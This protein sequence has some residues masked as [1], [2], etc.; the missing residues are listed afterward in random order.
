MD[1]NKIL[2]LIKSTKKLTVLFVED[3]DEVALNTLSI[4]KEFFGEI[5]YAKNGQEGV[6]KFNEETIDL[7]ISDINMP[8]LNGIEMLKEIKRLNSGVPALFMTAHN[9]LEY[10]QKAMD[11]NVK[12]YILKPMQLPKFIEI[13]EDIVAEIE[14]QNTTKSKIDYLMQSNKKLINIGY[15]IS[16][17]KDHNKLLEIILKGAK[18]L[19]NSDG[20]TIYI[21]D[22]NKKNLEFK[23]ALNSSLDLNFNCKSSRINLTP[24]PLYYDDEINHKNIAVVCAIEDKLININDI[25]KS[26]NYDFNGAI[27]F[28][29]KNNYK[30]ISMLVVPMKNR[31]NEVIG[32]I[33][34]INKLDEDNKTISFN[35]D[36]QLLITS[37]ASQAAMMFENNKLVEDLE[38]LLYSLIKSTGS[39]LDEK[40]P[41][42]AKHIDHVALISQIIADAINENETIFKDIKFSKNELEEIRLAAWLHDIGKIST[43]DHIIDKRTKLEAIYDR[44]ESI[45]LKFEL[46]KKDIEIAFLRGEIHLDVRNE[47]IDT[48]DNDFEFIKLIN[49]GDTIMSDEYLTKLDEVFNKYEIEVNYKKEKVITKNEFNNLSILRGTLTTEDRDIIN[50]HVV[51]TYNMLKNVP[52]PKR[53][54]NVPKI[55]G[56]HHKTLDGKGYASNEIMNDEMTIQDKILA[57]ADVFEAL[58]AR[59]RPYKEP[60]TLNQIANILLSMAQ[61]NQIDKDIVKLLFVNNIINTYA[62]KYLLPSQLDTVRVDFSTL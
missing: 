48:I 30:T 1:K 46:V 33:Q 22:D 53:F 8:V 13:L 41:Y 26:K 34:L 27:D 62:K 37:M 29:T 57:V 12:G 31:D 6:E 28:D 25:Y 14:N 2:N 38:I 10:Y 60:N 20:G 40:S 32:V 44:I 3:D 61:S 35:N 4:L 51:V 19:S 11:L 42:T 15:E 7:I 24:L 50:N 9:E 21:L 23:I 56:S 17:Q 47:A 59:D 39:A 58:S 45:E 55:A 36:D 16:N 54:R 52:F 43:P 5:F 49:H 18:E